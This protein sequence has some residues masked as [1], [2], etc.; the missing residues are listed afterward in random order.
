MQQAVDAAKIDERA[1]V[2]QAADDPLADLAGSEFFQQFLFRLGL[3]ALDHRPTAE[4][5]VP[6]V[7][8][9]LGD[10]AREFLPDELLD[11]FDAKRG[12]LAD[13]NKA[14]DAIDL[15]LETSLVVPRDVR[16]DDHAFGHLRPI[17][18]LDGRVGEAHLIEA[19]FGVEP[20]D[21]HVER[22]ARL[23]R[24]GELPKRDDALL[25]TG[26]LQE[27]I[28]AMHVDHFAALP[29]FGFKLG[30]DG[31]SGLAAFGLQ[32]F[33]DRHVAERFLQLLREFRR[34]FGRRL[35]GGTFSPVRVGTSNLRGA[36][37]RASGAGFGWNS[38]PAAACGSVGTLISPTSAPAVAL[39][40]GP[41]SVD[42]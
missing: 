26:Q 1:E 39:T 10:N 27:H 23:G 38:S 37:L 18:D 5:E 7:G 41:A 11:L 29:R 42:C 31:R 8:I 4:H 2:A 35:G 22:L 20:H 32:Q 21:E 13:G 15:D 17:S 30:P 25:A 24:V 12:D 3:L 16:F 40:G 14:A 6:A 33:I 19:V 9:R 28:V 36:L 34:Q